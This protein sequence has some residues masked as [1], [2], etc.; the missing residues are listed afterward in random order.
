VNPPRLSLLHS[1]LPLLVRSSL[2]LLVRLS[3]LLLVCSS[4]CLPLSCR[5]C[6]QS[7]FRGSGIMGGGDLPASS[8]VRSSLSG[9][10]PNPS[11]F[12]SWAF[13]PAYVVFGAFVLL[14]GSGTGHSLSGSRLGSRTFI[15]LRSFIC[16]CSFAGVGVRSSVTWHAP[17]HC[18]SQRAQQGEGKGRRGY[19]PGLGSLALVHSCSCGWLSSVSVDRALFVAASASNE[20]GEGWRTHLVRVR[21][22]GVR[23][24]ASVR[25][26]RVMWQSGPVRC[27]SQSQWP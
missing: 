12:S 21:F 26:R 18:G 25:Q 3:L 7:A 13:G 6:G 16:V 15:R 27:G 24:R 19:L 2:L 10:P 20:N 23:P 17:V 14:E 11:P 1:S 8:F 5:C 22:A 4:L 9:L